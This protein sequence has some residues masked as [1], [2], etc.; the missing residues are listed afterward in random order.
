[1]REERVDREVVE[2]SVHLHAG[3]D[4]LKTPAKP[5]YRRPALDAARQA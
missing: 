5:W 2:T 1:M 3:C 4:K